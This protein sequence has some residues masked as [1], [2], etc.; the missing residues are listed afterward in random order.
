MGGHNVELLTL[1]ILVVL[2]AFWCLPC[3]SSKLTF[4]SKVHSG[5]PSEC[6]IVGIDLNRS[7]IL[8]V[9]V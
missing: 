1:F 7:A 2:N 9:L 4:F 8:L 5:I 6:Q 3:F